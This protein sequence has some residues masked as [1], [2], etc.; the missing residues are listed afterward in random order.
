MAKPSFTVWCTSLLILIQNVNIPLSPMFIQDH[1]RRV[2]PKVFHQPIRMSPWPRW[3]LSSSKS[4]TGVVVHCAPSGTIIMAMV[5]CVIMA[6]PIKNMLSSNWLLVIHSLIWTG[7][8]FTVI[9]AA[10][11]WRRRL[12][13]FILTSSKLVYH[14]PVIMKTIS[15]TA[16]GARNIMV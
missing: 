6:W 10:V 16:G 1:K 12:C 3:A 5:I 4:A 8:G 13:W 14:R 2:S 9:R 11:L 15:T 7:S